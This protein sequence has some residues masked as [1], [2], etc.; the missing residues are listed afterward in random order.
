[1]L[2]GEANSLTMKT[3]KLIYTLLGLIGLLLITYSVP[4]KAVTYYQKDENTN[5]IQQTEDPKE[6]VSDS[7][8][9]WLD[10]LAEYECRDCGDGF[11]R[12]DS[13]EKYS[14][15][16]LQYQAETWLTWGKR[17]GFIA[18]EQQNIDDRIYDCGLQKEIAYALWQDESY[19]TYEKARNWYTSI[20]VRGL[21][22]PDGYQ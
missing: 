9:R 6:T 2:W 21:G 10:R 13:N 22:L 14:Y 3:T 1:M 17:Y 7:L 16:C 5:Q 11:K 19:T 12:L 20:Y 8:Y 15:G 18:V 4:G